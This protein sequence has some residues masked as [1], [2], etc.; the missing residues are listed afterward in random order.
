[1]KQATYLT[2]KTDFSFKPDGAKRA[3]HVKMGQIFWV[4]NSEISQ[5]NSGHI[6]IAR[7]GTGNCGHGYVFSSEQIMQYFTPENDLGNTI[8]EYLD[9]L[10]FPRSENT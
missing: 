1:M 8:E 2:A 5:V 3:V 7:K 4:T 6:L 10:S 9:A